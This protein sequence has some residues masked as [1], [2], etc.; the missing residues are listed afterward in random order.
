MGTLWWWS[1][2]AFWCVVQRQQAAGEAGRSHHVHGL[3]EQ[4]ASPLQLQVGSVLAAGICWEPPPAPAGLSA[5]LGCK[6]ELC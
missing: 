2:W 1:C 4:P 5:A 3:A 6:A